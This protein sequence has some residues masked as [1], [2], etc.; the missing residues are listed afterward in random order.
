MPMR[1][2]DVEGGMEGASKVVRAEARVEGLKE[3]WERRE[4]DSGVDEMG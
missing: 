3:M 1:M 4:G 2:S